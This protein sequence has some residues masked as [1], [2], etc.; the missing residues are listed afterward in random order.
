MSNNLRI[1]TVDGEQWVQTTEI[2]G[3]HHPHHFSR[4]LDAEGQEY[5]P[6]RPIPVSIYAAE[7]SSSIT[8]T[9]SDLDIGLSRD[10]DSITIWA[11]T[12]AAGT[13]SPVPV[14]V[15]VEGHLQ[16]DVLSSDWPQQ[17]F[18][19]S[20]P[21]EYSGMVV[22]GVQTGSPAPMVTQGTFT[23]LQFDHQGRLLVTLGPFAG[24]VRLTATTKSSAFTVWADDQALAPDYYVDIYRCSG[25]FTAGLPSPADPKTGAG[26]VV[27]IKN[28]GTGVITLSPDAGTIEDGVSLALSPRVSVVLRS[29]MLTDWEVL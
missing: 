14:L 6:D 17:P 19:S 20:P 4:L 23:P 29:N 13:G 28:T 22:L 27:W 25:T 5:G 18:D 15:D 9:G 11:H 7:G 1:Q 8:L 12:N 24:A 21:S 3:V 2:N 26:R 10:S 16:V